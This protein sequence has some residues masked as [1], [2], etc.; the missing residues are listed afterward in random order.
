MKT[1]KKQKAINSLNNQISV[2]K[3]CR[4]SLTRKNT[5]WGEGDVDARLMLVA[6]SPG[7]KE[8]SE[9]QMFIG[10]SGQIL[11]ELL[12]NGGINRK[13][14]FMTNLIKCMLP[15]NRRPKMD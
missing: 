7:E 13:S 8:D 12:S 9:N 1:G 6:L 2:C 3:K 14:I 5:L 11:N 10:P 15:K 4:L